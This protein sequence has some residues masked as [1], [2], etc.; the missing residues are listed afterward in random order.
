MVLQDGSIKIA[1]FFLAFSKKL[2][3]VAKAKT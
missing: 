3:V 2:A 1:N